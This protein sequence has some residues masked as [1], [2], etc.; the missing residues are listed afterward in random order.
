MDIRK[1]VICDRDVTKAECVA[2][3]G[4]GLACCRRCS[5]GA[6]DDWALEGNP[7]DDCLCGCEGDVESHRGGATRPA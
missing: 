7:P 5:D 3:G 1:C 6:R 4:D 2:W